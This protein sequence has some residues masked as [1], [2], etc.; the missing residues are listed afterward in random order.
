MRYERVRDILRN[1][2]ALKNRLGP[3][4]EPVDTRFGDKLFFSKEVIEVTNTIHAE[5]RD[6]HKVPKNDVLRLALRVMKILPTGSE[7]R[8]VTSLP[9]PEIR[10]EAAC[11]AAPV[12]SKKKTQATQGAL[13]P[14]SGTKAQSAG[15]STAKSNLRA[16]KTK[17]AVKAPATP[18]P[19]K[20]QKAAK[21]PRE[22]KSQAP[23]PAPLADQKAEPTLI[24]ESEL[25]PDK[26]PLH[27]PP[28][29]DPRKWPHY[30]VQSSVYSMLLSALN[31]SEHFEKFPGYESRQ[32]KL[33]A[34]IKEYQS[35][36]DPIRI[37]T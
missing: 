26:Q 10:T 27:L 12:E 21:Q 16:A 29:F 5:G 37:G 15:S 22:T 6:A 25:P 11:P 4:T 17:K 20:L 23:E 30:N 14:K 24:P 36:C 33:E 2:P 9:S 32:E 3:E 18:S 19:A 13:A 31:L 7:S 34:L 1:D 28:Q 8:P 35:T